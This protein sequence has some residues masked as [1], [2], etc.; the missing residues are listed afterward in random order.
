MQ[1][2]IAA[3]E[4]LAVDDPG[5]TAAL[6]AAADAVHAYFIQRELWRHA[7]ARCGDRE[8]RIP[9]AVLIRLGAA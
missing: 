8:Y 3:L 1:R 9:R 4:A 6:K 5:R 2:A 7:P